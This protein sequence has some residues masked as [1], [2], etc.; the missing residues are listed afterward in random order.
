EGHT[1]SSLV[2]LDDGW[3]ARFVVRDLEGAGLNRDH[4]AVVDRF[5]ALISAGSPAVY[6]ETEVWRRFA[7]F[8]VVNH[9][10]QLIA[11]LAEH[12]GSH[13]AELWALAG[14]LLADEAA[15]HGAAATVAPLRRLL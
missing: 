5:A 13:E 2:A 1:Q 8:V 15:R 9:L 4:P 6:D 7:Y 12:L 11:T 14:E 10:G 3:P